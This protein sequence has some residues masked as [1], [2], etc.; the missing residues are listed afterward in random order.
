MKKQNT[1]AYHPLT[2]GLVERLNRT[3]TDMLAK[4]VQAGGA[5]WDERLPYVLFAYRASLQ[6]STQESP[7]YLLYGRD[8]QLPTD[9][10]LRLPKECYQLDLGDYTEEIT[11]RMSAA[12]DEAQTQ[13]RKAQKK[14]KQQLSLIH[15]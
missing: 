3:L 14:Q 12:W 8:P 4:T 15:I 10:M 11:S 2:D 7:F 9:E 1:T 6:E 5:D 13:V